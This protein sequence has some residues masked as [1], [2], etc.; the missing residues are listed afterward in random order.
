MKRSMRGRIL[1]LCGHCCW[2]L[3]DARQRGR[4]ADLRRSAGKATGVHRAGRALADR[5]RLA[6]WA[7]QDRDGE[8]DTSLAI[9]ETTF[10]FGLT[11][12]PDIE[13]DTTPWR[14]DEPRWPGHPKAHGFGIVDRVYKQRLTR[15]MPRSG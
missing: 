10:K 14:L 9:G 2:L 13:I 12:A 3:A 8:R 7:L 5:D 1:I 15:P 4:A 11:T 6:D